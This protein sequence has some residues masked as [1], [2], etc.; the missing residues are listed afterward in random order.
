MLNGLRC[1]HLTHIGTSGWI[2]DHGCTTA[3]QRDWLVSCHLQTFHQTQCHKMSHMQTVSCRVKTDIKYCFSIVDEFLDFFLIGYLCDQ[4]SGNQFVV[5]CHWVSSCNLTFLIFLG[6]YVPL[7]HIYK[8]PNKNP[9]VLIIRTRGI[10]RVTTLIRMLFT[11]PASASAAT[12]Q[13]V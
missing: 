11:Q 8:N 13:C 1:H 2:T 6:L 12:L 3:D 10:S 4:T 5:K 9:L 7:L